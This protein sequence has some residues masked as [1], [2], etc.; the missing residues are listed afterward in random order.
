MFW[1]ALSFA[2][3]VALVLGGAYAAY[4][5]VF[6]VAGASR[7]SL[8]GATALVALGGYW[9]WLA[10]VRPWWQGRKAPRP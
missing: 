1:R 9:L 10:F 2:I 8:T 3:A 6:G 4:A 7:R 5:L